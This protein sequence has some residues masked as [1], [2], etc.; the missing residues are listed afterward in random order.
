MTTRPLHLVNIGESALSR[1]SGMGRV[2]WHWREEAIRRGHTFTHLGSND[3][4]EGTPPRLF[5]RAVRRRF[6]QVPGPV[7]CVLVHEPAAGAFLDAHVPLI[8]VSH[9]IERRLWELQLAGAAGPRPPLRTRILFPWWRLHQADRGLSR[10]GR[11]YVLNREDY[12]YVQRRYRR[13]PEDLFLFRNG[14]DLSIPAAPSL[15]P[16][17]LFIGQWRPRK[18]TDALV[19]AVTTLTPSVPGVRWTLAGTHVGVETVRLHFPASMR[20]RVDV[21]PQFSGDEE[22][23]LMAD[24]PVFVL[25]SLF[26]GQPLA[27][28]QA[29][30]AGCCCVTTDCC[31]QRD[32]IVDGVNGLLV[33]PGDGDALTAALGRVLTDG[34]L[35][36]RLGAAARASVQDRSWS[37]VSSD[38][39]DDVET[40]CRASAPRAR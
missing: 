28:L 23:A 13:S 37:A 11:V 15:A 25:P 18:G 36:A 7:D 3:V 27:L 5:P 29:M 40:F 31:G 9:G 2:V 1:A 17:V 4:P 16:H 39:I 21:L 6:A 12:A 20:D 38:V 24:A 26:E 35:R 33:P 8:V 19:R 32:V 22:W 30:A 10:G 34:P 14:T